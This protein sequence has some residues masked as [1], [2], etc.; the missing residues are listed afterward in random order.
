MSGVGGGP[1]L[2]RVPSV[3]SAR[4]KLVGPA[5]PLATVTM[6]SGSVMTSYSTELPPIVWANWRPMSSV[7]ESAA[8]LT[9]TY[10][11]VSQF[12]GVMVSLETLVVTPGAVAME[13][14]TVP[15]GSEMIAAW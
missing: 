15:E 4:A 7:T 10:C 3:S 14:V 6:T 9:I 5:P 13:I 1:Q 11:G 12:D 2:S 8:A